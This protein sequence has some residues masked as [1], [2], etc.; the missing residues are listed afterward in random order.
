MNEADF[1]SS[2]DCAFPYRRPLQWR[3]LSASAARI[4]SNAAFMVLHE[5]CR[6]PAS[7]R[8][9][10]A[11]RLAIIGH[12]RRRFRHPVLRIVHPAVDSYLSGKRLRPSAA[13][14]LMRRLAPHPGQFIALAICYFSAD[15][16]LGE[17]E[18]TYQEVVRQW[19]SSG[20]TRG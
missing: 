3:R 4:S 6:V 16:R 20:G 11:R 19:T 10:H 17:L 12:L 9:E 2:I 13:A 15:D 5:V 14:A 1:I 8:I 18:R 7:R